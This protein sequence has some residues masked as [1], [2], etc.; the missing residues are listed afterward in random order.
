MST[1]STSYASNGSGSLRQ[2]QEDDTDFTLWQIRMQEIIK[3]EKIIQCIHDTPPPLPPA[4]PSNSQTLP[5]YTAGSTVYDTWETKDSRAHGF[6]SEKLCD[7]LACKLVLMHGQTAKA[8]WELVKLTVGGSTNAVNDIFLLTIEIQ[9][10]K[11]T[12]SGDKTADVISFRSH[13]AKYYGMRTNA[14]RL[15]GSTALPNDQ[16]TMY[17]LQSLPSDTLWGTLR[18]TLLRAR[19]LTLNAIETE[20]VTNLHMNPAAS[21]VVE[22]HPS[23]STPSSSTI[24]ANATSTERRPKT[25][26][27]GFK[28]KWCDYHKECGHKTKDCEVLKKEKV[29]K[30][31]R[32]GKEKGKEKKSHHAS[33]DSSDS[34][35]SDSDESAHFVGNATVSTKL[36]AEISCYLLSEAKDKPTPSSS[37]PVH[38][39]T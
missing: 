15:G 4:V 18:T 34:S 17:A 27:S 1:M 12:P 36:K 28:A 7:G 30:E 32:K 3:K 11:W 24:S 37:T 8:L 35:S 26:R 19:P 5:Y 33:E 10:L 14:D 20:V 13:M 38:P 6:I 23:I 2:L 16:L 25:H 22:E 21:R 31:K 9:A 29:E 39:R